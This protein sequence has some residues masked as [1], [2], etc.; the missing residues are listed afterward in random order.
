[1]FEAHVYAE[2]DV[3]PRFCDQVT[4]SFGHFV[5]IEHRLPP[6][7]GSGQCMKSRCRLQ[8]VDYQFKRPALTDASSAPAQSLTSTYVRTYGRPKHTQPLLGPPCLETSQAKI[9]EGNM[10]RGEQN[11]RAPL[12]SRHHLPCSAKGPRPRTRLP[13]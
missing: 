2:Q 13:N 4:F 3:L 11:N 5:F 1:M 12:A 8:R 7:V 9:K 6:W 10:R